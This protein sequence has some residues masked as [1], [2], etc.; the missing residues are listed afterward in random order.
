MKYS[1]VRARI[2]TFFTNS[3]AK[4]EYKMTFMVNIF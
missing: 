3:K 1:V 2:R 4:M